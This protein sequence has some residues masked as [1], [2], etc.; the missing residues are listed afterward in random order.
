MATIIV[1]TGAFGDIVISSVKRSLGSRFL[2]GDKYIGRGNL[3]RLAPLM[4]SAPIYVSHYTG[5]LLGQLV[6]HF[7]S[8]Q[9][10]ELFFLRPH[11]IYL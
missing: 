1:V 3:E 6:N 9:C 8:S 4:F 2:D 5:L 11:N 7:E 10:W